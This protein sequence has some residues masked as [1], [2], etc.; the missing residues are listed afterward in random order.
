MSATAMET[1]QRPWGLTLVMGI[2]AIVFG[3]ILLWAPAKTKVEAY[4]ILVAL[5]GIYWLISGVIEIVAI[6]SDH[7]AWGWK[8]FV[9]IVSLIA[10]WYVL[11]YPVAAG[12]AL[13]RIA[14]L[15]LGI[16]G[17]IE[18]IVLLML[19]FKGGGWPAG[20][21]G[22]LAILFGVILLATWAVPGAGLAML[23]TAAVVGLV[24][25]V[26]MIVQAFRQRR[27]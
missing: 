20:I 22:G 16:W 4:Q 26:I 27:A 2:I 14:V 15:V 19:A 21:L 9:G 25:G 13:P 11:V 1:K 8:L 3:A 18:G 12:V 7:Q 17:L 23:W 5:I 6:F 10:G 24:G